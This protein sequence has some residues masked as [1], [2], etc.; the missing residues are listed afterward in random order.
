MLLSSIDISS[1]GL[2]DLRSKISIIPQDP[3]LFSGTIRSNLDPFNLY[4]DVQL[5]DALRRSYLV[6]DSPQ[7]VKSDA[8]EESSGSATPR[9]RFTL[10]SVVESEGANLSQGE[11]SLL[12]IARALVKDS[13]VVILDEATASVDLATDSKIQDTIQ[14]EF[15]DRTLLCIARQYLRCRERF[16]ELMLHAS[17]SADRLRTILAYDRILVLDAGT[18]AVGHS[19]KEW[20][21]SNANL[22]RGRNLTRRQ[23]YSGNAVSSGTCASVRRLPWKRF[24]KL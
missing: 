20:P 12:S 11:R 6:E 22:P 4:D 3:L 8:V 19:D 14:A 10:E 9:S 7:P 5:W 15:F 24:R 2:R 1:L 13:K 21:S 16:T 17:F 23:T 18:V